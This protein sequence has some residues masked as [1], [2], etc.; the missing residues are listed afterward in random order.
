MAIQRRL[1]RASRTHFSSNH[2]SA[3]KTSE[4]KI[5][6]FKW[7]R[8]S[9]VLSRAAL[10]ASPIAGLLS[11]QFAHAA[12]ANDIWTGTAAEWNAA[13]AWNGNNPP[14]SG[15]TLQF[16]ATGIAQLTSD[17]NISGLSVA[18]LTFAAG[19]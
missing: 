9:H 10:A 11:A 17:N 13:G 4:N 15:D 8:F 12:N 16:D 19:A 2:S 6:Q 7:R 5:V 14:V 3:K 1:G 18:G